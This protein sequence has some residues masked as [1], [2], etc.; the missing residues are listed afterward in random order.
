MGGLGLFGRP[1]PKRAVES[2]LAGSPF[3]KL[4]IEI[5]QTILVASAGQCGGLLSTCKELRNDFFGNDPGLIELLIKLHGPQKA[6]DRIVSGDRSATAAKAIRH[7]IDSGIELDIGEVYGHVSD[8]EMIREISEAF[9]ASD[10][11]MDRDDWKSAIEHAAAGGRVAAF[12]HAAES[13]GE[14]LYSTK[15]EICDFRTKVLKSAC[16]AGHIDMIR[17]M[18]CHPAE[19][20]A[21]ANHISCFREAARYGQN[22]VIEILLEHLEHKNINCSGLLYDAAISAA[23]AKQF[24]T[25][26]LALRRMS[27]ISDPLWP[28]A[29]TSTGNMVSTCLHEIIKVG[30]TPDEM[31]TYLVR[32][33]DFY[34]ESVRLL[35]SVV[36]EKT[37]FKNPE[38]SKKK[39]LLILE[40]ISP[41]T[42]VSKIGSFLNDKGF[43]TYRK[44]YIQKNLNKN[45]K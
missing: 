11:K 31:K 20:R 6:I 25:L 45:K 32:C 4:P 15:R 33:R 5:I 21:E 7:V 41:F 18:L 10:V 30:A 29:S 35:L 28:Q 40:A 3:I 2:C 16:G 36:E 42:F 39:R 43:E 37:R 8:E 24:E 27:L 26:D 34:D 9:D 13:M 38:R 19:F 12:L 44:T 1:P 14:A 23:K 22:E 17:T